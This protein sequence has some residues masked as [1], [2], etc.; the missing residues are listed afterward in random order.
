MTQSKNAL[1]FLK[2]QATGPRPGVGLRS[3]SAAE[4]ERVDRG[5]NHRNRDGDGELLIEPAGHAAHEGDGH[6]HRAKNQGDGHHRAGH[7]LHRLARRIH[8]REPALDVMLHGL[9]NDDGVIDHNTDGEHQPEHGE[10]VD[11]ETE[12][13]E[14]D[15]HA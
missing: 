6:E 11:A 5:E 8:R 12:Q 9:D 10:R 13:R 4:R 14:G 1:N 2:N 3:S 7:F 15:E